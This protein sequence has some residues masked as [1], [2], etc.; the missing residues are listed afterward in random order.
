MSSVI[1]MEV[2][3]EPFSRDEIGKIHDATVR[4]LEGTGVKVLEEEAVRLLTGAGAGYDKGTRAVRIPERVLMDSISAA[5]SRF[6]LCSRDGKHDLSFGE[7]KVHLSSMGTAVQVEGLDGVVRPSTAKDLEDFLRLTDA[8]PN[9]DHSSWACWPRDVPERI[10]PLEAIRLSFVHSNK[11]VDGWN[12]G[13]VATEESLELASM[14]AGG[15]DALAERPLVLGFAN[16][17]SPLTLS[18]ESTEGLISYARAGQ[19]C[20]YPPECMAGG[21]SPAT[22]AGLLVQQNAEV[23]AS[24]AV[25]QL[26]NPGA[27]S[28]YSSVSG[29]MDMRTGAIALGGPEVGLIMAGT[30]QLARRYKVPCRGTGGNTES[31]LPDY[32]A[33][34]E[35]ANTLLMAGLSGIDFVYD[36]AGSI[37]SSLTASFAKMVLDDALCGGVKRVLSGVEVDEESLAVEVIGSAGPKGA[38]L[39]HPHTLRHF[40]R[41]AFVP[42]QF[43]RGPRSAWA[44][45]DIVEKARERAREILREH[46]VA[47]PLDPEV[48]R[49]MAAYIKSVSKK[50]RA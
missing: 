1:S 37:E 33:G 39:S 4:V 27:P 49:R 38:F 10:A 28:I 46:E 50:P 30:A 24:I 14:V 47:V 44:S 7:G 18:K 17:V 12:W 32:Q 29:T 19:P 13:T 35:A 43:W 11:T 8:L 31:M 22:I 2:R 5:P 21:T 40:R 3:L 23:L 42:P 45:E 15:R 41:E 26:A 34:A 25:A 20:V 16:P 9:I 36:A 48:E 6:K